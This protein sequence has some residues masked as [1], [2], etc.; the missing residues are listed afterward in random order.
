MAISQVIT[1]LPPAPQRSQPADFVVKADAHVASLTGFVDETN[2][3]IGEINTTQTEINASESNATNSETNAESSASSAASS[4][5][6]KGEWSALVGALNIPASVSHLGSVWLLLNNL[7]D[8]ATSEPSVTAD[9]LALTGSTWNNPKTVNFDIIAGQSYQIDGSGGTVDGDLPATVAINEE[10]IIH[11]ESISTNLVR[12]LN[13][14]FSIKGAGDILLAGDNLILEA[15][16][17][18]H[19]VARSST[20]LEVV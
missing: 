14:N 15:G 8:V 1:D 19:L 12:V 18:A 16:D 20:V 10:F 6:Y 5:N 13:P 3:V 7:A 2:I 9:W 17:T 11:N 4:A